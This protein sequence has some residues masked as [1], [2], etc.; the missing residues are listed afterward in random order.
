MHLSAK[1]TASRGAG[2]L[3]VND[4]FS[5][6]SSRTRFFRAPLS[7]TIR[8]MSSWVQA[9]CRSR[10]WP[11]SSPIRSRWPRIS[12][13]AVFRAASVFRATFAPGGFEFLLRR[14]P[15]LDPLPGR[16]AHSLADE[17]A[18]TG[19]FVEERAGDVREPRDRGSSDRRPGFG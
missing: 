16:L 11:R 13:W 17:G 6:V 12:V 3:S 14:V 19:V 9:D 8:A 1:R 2:N 7:V 15:V 10:I 4:L 18:R 5:P